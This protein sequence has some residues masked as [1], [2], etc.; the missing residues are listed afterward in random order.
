MPAIELGHSAKAHR[1]R[2]QVMNHKLGQ[3]KSNDNAYC[4]WN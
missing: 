2:D 1:G 3:D 4:P